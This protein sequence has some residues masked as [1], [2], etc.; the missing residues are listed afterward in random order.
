VAAADALGGVVESGADAELLSVVT[1]CE[2]ATRRLDRVTVDAVAVLER[3]GLFTERGYPSTVSALTD[4]VGW[5]QFE[6][7]RRVVAAE[8]VGVRTSL[9]GAV[10]PA[11]SPA[12]GAVFTAAKASLRHV[13]VIARVLGS[14]A[15]Q[16]LTLERW[17]G[18]EQ[19]LAGKTD[20][21]SPTELHRWGSALVEMLDQDGEPPDDGPPPGVNE[22]FLTG[23]PSGSGGRVT[24]RWDDAAMFDTIAA[25]LDAKATPRTG[26]DDRSG[27]ERTAEALAEVCGY[28]LDHAP[29]SVVPDTGGRARR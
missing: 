7:R 26:D 14:R 21:Y 4:V 3:R 12:T 27:A 5:E 15:A 6:A 17:A 16:R 9:D 18:V 19:Q 2:G 1:L 8:H 25:L 13:E 20:Q 28:V 10:L 11:R 22:L 23:N 29:T 24:G